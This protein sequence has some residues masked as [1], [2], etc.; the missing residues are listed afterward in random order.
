[1]A[2]VPRTILLVVTTGGFT[3]AGITLRLTRDLSR[4][5]PVLELGKILSA[6]GHNIE[7]ATLDGQ[8]NWVG[9]YEFVANVHLL[10]PGPTEEQMDSHYLRMRDWDM[11]RG[12]ATTME[13]K[14]MFDSFWPQTYKRLKAIMEDD[15]S[16]K[17]G[18]IVADF[19]ADA[20]KDVHFEYRVPLAV[21][22]PQMPHLMFPCSYIPGEPGFQIEGTLTSEDASMWL[23]LRNEWVVIRALPQIVKLS[24]FTRAMRRKAGVGY[25]LPSPT[26]PDYLVLVNSFYGLE[27]PKDL[28]PLCALVGPILGDEFP[29]LNDATDR[30]L[31]GHGKTVYV[32]LGTHVILTNDDTAK[33]VNGL[34]RLLA[35][36]LVDGV[37]WAVG[38]SGRRDMDGGQ[39]FQHQG[40]TLRLG[41]L[42]DGRHP[43]WL[44]TLFAPQRA[45][46]DS[47]SVCLY[48]THGGGSSA[49]EGV[50][51]GKPMLSMGIFSDQ[52][53]NM[54][55]L[56]GAGV[57]EPLN[58]FRFT[59]DELYTKARTML[60]DEQGLYAR[61][62]LR[63][64]RIARVAARRK[65][66]AADLIEEL[67]YDAE[68][69]FRGDRELRP[70]HLQT[71]DMRMPMY[72]A[73][74]WDLMAAGAV[75]VASV[76]GLGI[77]LGKMLWMHR[78]LPHFAPLLDN[79]GN[80]PRNIRLKCRKSLD[81]TVPI[82]LAHLLAH[83]E[84]ALEL[85]NG[86]LDA[87][88]VLLEQL[89]VA[90][91]RVRHIPLIRAAVLAGII[92]DGN[93]GVVGQVGDLARKKV[94]RL[95]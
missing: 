44:F 72:K 58:K 27:V 11:S 40:Q 19:F 13:S 3:H 89:D 37:I 2:E 36:G 94:R 35:E 7:F 82:T 53:A 14:F 66:H 46:L 15:S 61:N 43:D 56:V 41:D 67:M 12:V 23:R 6:R 17:P 87:D 69:R 38:R 31:A 1:M 75:V 39:T 24:R 10:G 81:N 65:H 21:V 83:L 33:I 92:H 80:G 57:A 79:L 20:V 86:D 71:A 84:L 91:R 59:S 49:N 95:I 52:V 18:M 62:V 29:P 34:L 60:R 22:W 45:I 78:N 30:F 85:V 32:A 76:S 64:R 9:G 63:L 50:Y 16:A 42:M 48:F 47:D 68:L 77:T 51:H 93:L 73:R 90:V 5:A 55:R 25:D 54:T 74:N 88:D 8:E 28:P 70:M 4:A 26:K